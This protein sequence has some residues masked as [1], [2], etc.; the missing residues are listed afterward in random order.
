MSKRTGLKICRATMVGVGIWKTLLFQLLVNTIVIGSTGEDQNFD[1]I[2]HSTEDILKQQLED[3]VKIKNDKKFIEPNLHPEH[4]PFYFTNHPSDAEACQANVS[5]PHKDAMDTGHCWGYEEGCEKDN[6][7]GYPVCDKLHEAWAPSLEKLAD[8]FFEI[9]DFGYVKEMR[10]SM[11]SFC[12]PQKQY[13]SSLEC[14]KFLRHCRASNILMDFS[15]LQSK[16]S[17][18]RFRSDFFKAGQLGGN[19]EL[20]QGKLLAESDHRSELQSWYGELHVYESID[21]QIPHPQNCDIIIHKPTY[22]IKL[23]AG[24]NM[25]HHFCDF[26][27]IYI[28]QHINNSFS[29]DVNIV[30]WDTTSFGY[31]DL[32]EIMWPVFTDYPPI[33]LKTWEGQK[34]C[35]KEAVFT[36]LPRMQRGFFYNMPLVPDCHDSG[37]MR[38]FSQHVVHRLGIKQEGP[39]KGKVRVTLLSRNT[40][41]RNIVNQDELVAAMKNEK[42]LIVNVVEY[43]RNINFLEQLKITHNSDIFIGMHG[44]GLTHLLFQPDWGVLFELYNCEDP[45]C[46]KDL[47]SLR[48]TEYIT[49][50]RVLKLAK[51]NEVDHP[52]LHKPH[53]KFADYSFDVKEFMRIL[54]KGVY[55][56]KNHPKFK[57][58]RRQL[59]DEL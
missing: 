6:M 23:D 42:D 4:Y 18:N 19:C 29:S 45:R 33:P 57:E 32:F 22:L 36:L 13:D 40:K 27:N 11:Q 56:V 9:A 17:R 58:L 30:M 10:L 28:S 35:I 24:I 41:H 1:G 37:I 46:Y 8:K 38:A 44:A 16:E 39:A 51:H 54:K 14:T 15:N 53:A 2:T 50:Q 26:V 55:H 3:K 47:T 52:S 31:Y 25:Y 20:D 49:W 7:P 21:L 43:N 5:C 59:R 48:G 34:V 12:T